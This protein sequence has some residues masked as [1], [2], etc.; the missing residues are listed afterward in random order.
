MCKSRIF[1]EIL[2]AVSEETEVPADCILSKSSRTD[3]VDARW[4]VVFLLYKSGVYPIH[5][6]EFLRITPRYVQY[7]ISKFEERI[8]SRHI[9]CI[10][11]ETIKTFFKI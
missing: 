1:N 6:A 10:N 3:V 7:I 4:I 2:K 5:I 8:S 9:M 11:Y